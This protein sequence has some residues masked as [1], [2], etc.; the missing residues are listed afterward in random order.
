MGF[1]KK[2]EN[3]DIILFGTSHVIFGISAKEMTRELSLKYGR[4]VNVFNMGLVYGE[5]AIFPAKILQRDNAK[6]K[7][8]LLDVYTEFKDTS[9]PE[10]NATERRDILSGAFR[11]GKIWSHYYSD[12]ILDPLLPALRPEGVYE[13]TPWLHR[14]LGDT[15]FRTFEYGDNAGVWLATYGE[16]YLTSDA[17]P[18]GT[19]D[20]FAERPNRFVDYSPQASKILGE[21]HEDTIGMLIPFEGSRFAVIPISPIIRIDPA[22]LRYIDQHH[23]NAAS[24]AEVTNQIIKWLENEDSTWRK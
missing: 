2:I 12:W 14:C 4:P 17:H 6:N 15:L 13:G 20:P 8:V 23:V 11:A 19:G 9:S 7:T 16:R 3:A 18:L 5:S 21:M 24:R 22:R 10:A 1:G